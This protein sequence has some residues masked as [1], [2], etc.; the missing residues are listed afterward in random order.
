MT[1]TV[2]IFGDSYAD[3]DY[4]VTDMYTAWPEKLHE[5]YE[6]YNFAKAG[7]GPD[8]S[9][10]QLVKQLKKTSIDKLQTV[11]V[12][13]LISDINRFNMKFFNN[14]GDQHLS[15]YLIYED[16]KTPFRDQVTKY[17]PYKKFMRQFLELY[18]FNSSYLETELIKTIS[19]LKCYSELFEKMLIWPVF[20]EMSNSYI[21]STKN[22]II[23]PKSL[24]LLEGV[25]EGG[26]EKYRNNHLTEPNHM[27]MI[28][29]L[30]NWIDNN[31][32]VDFEKFI[33]IN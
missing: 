31:I 15:T 32:P 10:Q 17:S 21:T 14:A 4:K 16:I 23:M 19:L 13:F 6:V 9:V 33:K 2:W 11:S 30:V 18:I 28:E 26:N 22:C 27:V 20:Q 3:Q 25:K 5:N 24:Y 1:K 12:I 8:Y 7:S 29:Q